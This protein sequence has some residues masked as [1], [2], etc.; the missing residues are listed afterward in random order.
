MM[1]SVLTYG[2]P[3]Y[4]IYARLRFYRGGITKWGI[5]VWASGAYTSTGMIRSTPWKA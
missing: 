5:V 3:R 2:E 1:C 4:A